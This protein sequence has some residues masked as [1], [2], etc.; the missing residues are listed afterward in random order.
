MLK[1]I[2]KSIFGACIV[3]VFYFLT[4]WVGPFFV[5]DFPLHLIMGISFILGQ[6]SMF[7]VVAINI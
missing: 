7:L 5:A 4:V 1:S 6:I 3:L 2:L